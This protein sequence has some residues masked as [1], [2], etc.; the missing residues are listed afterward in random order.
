MDV[1]G[2]SVALN[3]IEIS[4]HKRYIGIVKFRRIRF[5]V[6]RHRQRVI[7]FVRFKFLRRKIIIRTVRNGIR[8]ANTALGVAVHG[9][10]VLLRRS[11]AGHGEIA[12]DVLDGIGAVAVIDN[13]NILAVHHRLDVG[14]I[15]VALVLIRLGEGVVRAVLYGQIARKDGIERDV[16]HR[17]D[18]EHCFRIQKLRFRRVLRNGVRRLVDLR[19]RHSHR[20]G[21]RRR[22]LDLE[23][24]R[25][26][27]AEVFRL[28][29]GLHMDLA[30]RCRVADAGVLQFIGIVGENHVRRVERGLVRRVA[31]RHGNG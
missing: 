27:L 26:R 25:E 30:G 22:G 19:A 11:L 5:P 17:L 23:V 7:V 1:A 12:G 28:A 8:N 20:R 2:D 6:D 16:V 18:R 15:V 3:G 24:Q 9:D 4:V 13:F 21:A 14:V 31:E 29:V 10:R